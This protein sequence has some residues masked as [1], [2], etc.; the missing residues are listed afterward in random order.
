[1]S[2]AGVDYDR[3][4]P[5]PKHCGSTEPHDVHVDW[6]YGGNYTVCTGQLAVNDEVS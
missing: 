1:M 4:P 3:P 2:Y 6:H 5:T